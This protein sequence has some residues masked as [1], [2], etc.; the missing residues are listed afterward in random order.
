MKELLPVG[1]IILLEGASK[2]TVIMGIL[3]KN[4]EQPDTVYDYLGVPYPEGYMGPGSSYLFQHE[5][6]AEVIARGYE[7]EDRDKMMALVSTV[8]EK[9]NQ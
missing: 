2:K 9:T 8:L 6:I 7:D 5:H 1:S 4:E 3:Q